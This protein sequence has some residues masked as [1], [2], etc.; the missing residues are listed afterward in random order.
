MAIVFKP[1]LLPHKLELDDDKLNLLA[2]KIKFA[3]KK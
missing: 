3:F 2:E 1:V